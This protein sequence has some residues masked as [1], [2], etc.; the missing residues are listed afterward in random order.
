[1]TDVSIFMHFIDMYLYNINLF[2]DVH[3]LSRIIMVQWK[4]AN[5][6]KGNDPTIGDTPI[7]HWTM[8]MGGRVI[9][10]YIM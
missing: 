6:L 1:M 8:I 10:T 4:M 5:Y 3:T 7:F 2:E 9:Y